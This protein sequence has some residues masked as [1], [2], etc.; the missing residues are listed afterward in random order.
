MSEWKEYK[1]GN[2]AI[3]VDC[4]H[5]TAPIVDYGD[6]ISVR[7]ANILN[8]KIEFSKSNRVTD[9]Y[10]NKQPLHPVFNEITS[11]LNW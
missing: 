10:E 2:M 4:E 7:T 8:G 3:I 11:L 6:F 5:Q 1:L 9:H